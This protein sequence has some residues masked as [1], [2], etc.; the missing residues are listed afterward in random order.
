MAH[1]STHG[2]H[3][4]GGAVPHP[5][6]P[7]NHEVTDIPLTG[8]TRAA[9]V[10][11]ILVGVIMAIVYGAWAF[12]GAQATKGDPGPP[13]MADKDYGRRLPPTPRV[14]STPADDLGRYRAMQDSKLESYGWVDRNAGVVHIP[15]ERAIE[16]TAARAS[17]IADPK[18]AELPAAS[19][20]DGPA[21]AAP[22]TAAPPSPAPGTAKPPA[23]VH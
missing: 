6:P 18:A 15:I 20:P 19:A 1:T 13:P 2:G 5:G 21:P 10:T 11:L 17:T 14:Q 7:V 4:Q 12:F 16:L 22:T 8:T 9:I 3:S 23:P